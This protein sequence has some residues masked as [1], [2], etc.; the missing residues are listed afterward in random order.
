MHSPLIT[1]LTDFGLQDAYV[2][3][4]KG[5]ILS[6]CPAARLVDISHLIVAGNVRSAGY[7]LG[8]SWRYFPA[9]AIH[10]C[11]VDPGVG[12]DR[13]ILGAKV[14]DHLFLAPDN[15]LLSEVFAQA[16]PTKVVSVENQELFVQPVSRTF[17]GRDIF[18]PAAAALAAGRKLEELG[19]AADRWI[20][21]PALAPL[22][23]ANN[24]IMGRIVHIDRFGNLIT[25]LT[26]LEVGE[27]S[28]IHAGGHVIHGV[29]GHYAAAE[30]GQLLAVIGST[31]R[32]EISINHGDAARQLGAS[33]G[34]PVWTGK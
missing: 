16:K 8:T 13:R 31:G 21:L 29:Q 10:V 4:M 6:R 32:V 17:H 18:S 34:D 1:L 30:R 26:A 11:V 24:T 20:Q 22:V 2:G 25:N 12:S 28:T 15:G 23:E 9:G 7:L 33:V 14:A 27:N 5:V 19:P 3:I